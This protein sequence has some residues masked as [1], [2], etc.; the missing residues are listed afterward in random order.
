MTI[1]SAN[2]KGRVKHMLEHAICSGAS[3]M[4]NQREQNGTEFSRRP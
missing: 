3:G 1:N 4:Q 2:W